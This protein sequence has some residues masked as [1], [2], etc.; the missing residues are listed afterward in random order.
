[1]NDI[2]DTKIITV[3]FAPGI[4]LVGRQ[5]SPETTPTRTNGYFES[6][7][8]FRRHAEIWAAENGKIWLWDVKSSNGTYINGERLSLENQVSEPCVLKEEDVLELGVDI[9]SED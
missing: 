1:M 4:V 7:A 2:L 6:E 3:P 9:K 8:V 5:M